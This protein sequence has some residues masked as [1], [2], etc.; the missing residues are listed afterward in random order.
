MILWFAITNAFN[1]LGGL[2]TTQ[3]ASGLDEGNEVVV[4]QSSTL[5]LST[6]LHTLFQPAMYLPT[7][8]LCIIG[9]IAGYWLTTW[10]IEKKLS[11]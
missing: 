8:I 1:L 10:I 2:I 11:V 6:S 5:F 3:L 7:M 9:S 4:T